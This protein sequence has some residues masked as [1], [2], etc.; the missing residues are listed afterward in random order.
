MALGGFPPDPSSSSSLLAS[1]FDAAGEDLDD[2]DA[3]RARLLE[4]AHDL[5]CRLGPQRMT[6]EDV[7]RAAGVSRITVYRRFATKDVLIQ[8]VVRLEFRRY[9]RRFRQ[10]IARC[11][12]V[13]ERVAVGFAT[14]LRVFRTNP[15]IRGL[16][17]QDSGV[18]L[19]SV[20]GDG[21]LTTEVVR[22]FI[23]AQLRKETEAGTIPPAVDTEL[24]AEVMVRLTT[25]Y[26]VTPSRLLDVDDDEVMKEVARIALVPLLG[27][28]R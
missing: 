3:I 25:S 27:S 14:S 7:A 8:H 2:R 20:V 4:S 13:G 6:M 11:E 9:L 28:E 24:V 17:D 18:F 19:A 10:E 1:A 16:M 26:L 22:R 23:A 5:L 12:T 15:L 21:G